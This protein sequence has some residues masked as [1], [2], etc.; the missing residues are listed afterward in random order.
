MPQVLSGMGNGFFQSL[1]ARTSGEGQPIA[2]RIEL[3]P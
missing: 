1:A 2:E 3:V